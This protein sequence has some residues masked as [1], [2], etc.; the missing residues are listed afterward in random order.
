MRKNKP[1]FDLSLR[2]IGNKKNE[3]NDKLFHSFL[4][5]SKQKWAI[6]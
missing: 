3:K 2:S 5:K 4:V 6:L 1:L